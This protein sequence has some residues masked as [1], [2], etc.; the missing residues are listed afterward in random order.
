M[1]N[2]VKYD[3]TKA[4]FK[5]DELKDMVDHL[6][7]VLSTLRDDMDFAISENNEEMMDYVYNKR[8]EVNKLLTKV[9][10]MI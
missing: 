8:V 10:G 9:E 4:T 1:K 5:N 2:K 3:G 7:L 6:N